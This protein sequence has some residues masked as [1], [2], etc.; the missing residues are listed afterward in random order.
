MTT[1]KKFGKGS[2]YIT[3]SHSNNIDFRACACG[4]TTQSINLGKIHVPKEMFGKKVRFKVE[5]MEE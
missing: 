2:Y 1:V 3:K 4:N 5:I